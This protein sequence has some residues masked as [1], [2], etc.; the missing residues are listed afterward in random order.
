MP[1]SHLFCQNYNYWQFTSSYQEW[2][3]PWSRTYE[4]GERCGDA[5]D[6]EACPRRVYSHTQY[7]RGRTCKIPEIQIGM[8][9]WKRWFADSRHITL[10]SHHYTTRDTKTDQI[11]LN[12]ATNCSWKESGENT[13]RLWYK[14]K[15]RTSVRDEHCIWQWDFYICPYIFSQVYTPSTREEWK[16]LPPTFYMCWIRTFA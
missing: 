13:T 3:Q 7:C 14:D 1:C 4:S 5:A 16:H 2:P 15:F 12:R 9:T 10:W 6:E 11:Y 8:K